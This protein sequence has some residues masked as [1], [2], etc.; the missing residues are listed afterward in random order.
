M[1][2]LQ[3]A[4]CSAGPARACLSLVDDDRV[5]LFMSDQILVEVRDV[6]T[7]PKSQ[8]KFPMLTL[9]SVNEFSRDVAR[10]SVVLANVPNAYSNLRDP[11]DEP[12][13]NVAIAANADYLVSR[14]LDLLDLMKDADFRQQYPS[15]TILNPV[16]FLQ[17][18]AHRELTEHQETS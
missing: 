1:V 12:Y 11:K 18:M 7:R 15:L 13:L 3:G 9:E 4:G 5:I 6:L 2:F 16:A 10:K 17:V 8:R 14:D